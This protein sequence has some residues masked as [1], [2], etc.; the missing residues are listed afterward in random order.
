MKRR[1]F[2]I[3]AAAAVAGSRTVWAQGTK[4]APAAKLDRIAIMT[5]NFQSI[6][7]V[8]DVDDNPNR[9]ARASTSRRGSRQVRVHKSRS[10][11]P[12]QFH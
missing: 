12:L 3:S 1:E 4:Q 7:K 5:L 11:L 10:A 8:P 9:N 2:L 6:L